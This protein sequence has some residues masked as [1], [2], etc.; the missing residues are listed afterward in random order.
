MSPVVANPLGPNIPRRGNRFSQWL[1]IF[2]LR[3]F[4]WS[5]TGTMPDVPKAIAVI[6][7]H[8][9]NIDGFVAAGAILALRL[10]IGAMAKADIFKGP[11]GGFF[12]WLG[13]I[14]IDRS[15][16]KDIV[17]QS[18]SRYREHEQLWIGIAPEGTRHGAGEW[19]TGFYRIAE[20]AQIPMIPITFDYGRKQ[21][22]ILNPVQPSGDMEA[23]M[24]NIVEQ[25]RG[26]TPRHPSRLSGP[27]A[28]Q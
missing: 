8:T 2:C 12:R 27:L 11:M 5:I 18:V 10:R 9:S 24:K 21:V 28:K 15:N 22:R 3:L 16:P 25:L 14:P 7:P 26:V 20:G 23:D 1:G 6:A 17:A 19:K 4:G 13:G